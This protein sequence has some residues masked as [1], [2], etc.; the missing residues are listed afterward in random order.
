MEIYDARRLKRIQRYVDTYEKPPR[1]SKGYRKH[2]REAAW[3]ERKRQEKL[4]A[5]GK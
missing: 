2:V 4:R 3:R 5:M 1:K